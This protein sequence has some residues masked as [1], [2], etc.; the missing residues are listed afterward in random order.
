M[1][2]SQTFLALS[3]ASYSYC[4]TSFESDHV[5]KCGLVECM[6]IRVRF[7][8]S[9]ECNLRHFIAANI[10]HQWE[11]WIFFF[12]FFSKSTSLPLLLYFWLWA[13]HGDCSVRLGFLHRL[14]FGTFWLAEAAQAMGTQNPLWSWS[15]TTHL[16]T[17][18]VLAETWWVAGCPL[19][20]LE[21]RPEY[22]QQLVK[23]S[24]VATTTWLEE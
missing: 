9:N 16:K 5:V 19:Y 7:Q 2:L 15:T 1:S 3:P 21:G 17:L 10:S 22:N 14:P 18:S 13:R 6:M 23:S 11:G 8:L 20:L 4:P 12:F 24:T